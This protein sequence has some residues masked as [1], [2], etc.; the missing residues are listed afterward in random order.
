MQKTI[1]ENTNKNFLQS[2]GNKTKLCVLENVLS[3]I[4]YDAL[5]LD[6]D[7]KEYNKNIITESVHKFLDERGGYKYG[8]I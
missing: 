7:F 4:Y 2:L 8:F 1:K 6:D 5:Y 3:S